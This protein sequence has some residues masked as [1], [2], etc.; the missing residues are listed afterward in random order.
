[1]LLQ[2]LPPLSPGSRCVREL[3]ILSYE[4]FHESIQYILEINCGAPGSAPEVTYYN[5]HRGASVS[6]WL[7]GWDVGVEDIL[8]LERSIAL[9]GWKEDREILLTGQGAHQ[10]PTNSHGTE[11]GRV[12]IRER[13][14]G[15]PLFYG[16]GTIISELYYDILPKSALPDSDSLPP[17][18]VVITL[19]ALWGEQDLD[20]GG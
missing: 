13:V 7:R 3:S 9:Y 6:V 14:R 19:T 16:R 17:L 18:V 10:H 8:K 5:D 4:T 12:F 20:M 15:N 11:T 1:M 2:P